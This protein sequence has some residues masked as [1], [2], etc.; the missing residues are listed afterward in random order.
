VGF[1]SEARGSHGLAASQDS[2]LAITPADQRRIFVFSFR[3]DQGRSV[4]QGGTGLGTSRAI[5]AAIV[6]RHHGQ[7]LWPQPSVGSEVSPF[8]VKLPIAA[9]AQG[10]TLLKLIFSVTVPVRWR[11][12]E[13]EV[14]GQRGESD[15]KRFQTTRAWRPPLLAFAHCRGFSG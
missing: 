12:L 1:E 14:Q 11:E 4:V 13:S 6:R 3:S 10:G 5:V 15:G 9:E 2:V 7:I 8:S